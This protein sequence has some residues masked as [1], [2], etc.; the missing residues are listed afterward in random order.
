[1]TLHES[2]RELIPV[3]HKF[4]FWVDHNNLYGYCP[5]KKELKKV[6]DHMWLDRVICWGCGLRIPRIDL[7]FL[8]KEETEEL[9]K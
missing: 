5:I 2:M 7:M 6:G 4:T 9:K 8:S 3:P 1:M